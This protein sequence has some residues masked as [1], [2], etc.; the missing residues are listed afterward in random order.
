MASNDKITGLM[1]N[2]KIMGPNAET[3]ASEVVTTDHEGYAMM[4][5]SKK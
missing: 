3:S 4:F 1:I 2:N 5:Q